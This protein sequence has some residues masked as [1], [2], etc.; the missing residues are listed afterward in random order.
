MLW[1]INVPFITGNMDIIGLNIIVSGNQ[2]QILIF[3]FIFFW[4]HF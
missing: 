2:F 3:K 4:K 1:T